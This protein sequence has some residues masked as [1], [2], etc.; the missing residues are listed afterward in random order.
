MEN[1]KL[2]STFPV[3]ISFLR[4]DV[5]VKEQIQLNLSLVRNKATILTYL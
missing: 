3:K 1:L 4:K 2:C 5:D